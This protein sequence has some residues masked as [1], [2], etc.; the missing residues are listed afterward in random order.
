MNDLKT[1]KYIVYPGYVY[2]QNDGDR[3]YI[4]FRKLITLYG[5]HPDECVNADELHPAHNIFGLCPLRP[6]YDGNYKL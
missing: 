4:S 5:V 3:H 2:S 6:K 1:K